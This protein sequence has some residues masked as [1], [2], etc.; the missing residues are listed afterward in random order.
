[1]SQYC[2]VCDTD[3]VVE[4]GTQGTVCT[5]CGEVLEESRFD[6][7]GWCCRFIEIEF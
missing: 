3:V 6:N 2:H 7:S 5:Q 1:M 4:S